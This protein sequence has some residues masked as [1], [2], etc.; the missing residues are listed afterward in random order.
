MH[1]K[2]KIISEN[3]ERL[4]I[5]EKKYDPH[6]GEGSLLEREKVY[7]SDVEANLYLPKSMIN[8]NTF[9]YDLLECKNF[10]DYSNKIGK[11]LAEVFASFQ[12]IRFE[13][14]FE[15]WSILTILIQ[16]KETLEEVPFK[17]RLAQQLLLLELEKMRLAGVPIRI[18]LLKARQWGGSTL[19]QMYMFWIQQIHKERWHLAVCAQDDGAANNISEMYRR[20]SKSYPEAVSTITFKPYARSPK[21]IVNNERGGIIGVGSVNNPDQFR[22]FNYTMLH[23][24]EPGVWEDTPKRTAGQLVAS[25]RSIITKQPLT[26]IA[27]ESTAKGVGTFFHNEWLSAEKES[28]SYKAVFIPW[29]KIEMYQMPITDYSS[30]IDG[31]NE[32]DWFCWKEGATLEGIN[33]YNVH[34]EGENYDDW[35]MYNE[36]PTTSTEAFVASGQRY[37][38]PKITTNARKHVVKPKFRGTIHP[39]ECRSKEDIKHSHFVGTPRG[40]LEIWKM[41]KPLVKVKGKLH[42]CVNRY[43]VFGDIGGVSDKADF[44]S[45]TVLDRY[46]MLYG[47]WPEV[48]ADWHGH[49]D[50]DLFAWIAAQL[51]YLYD[52]ALMA[53][54]TN[55]LRK[56]KSSGDHFLT[57][58]DNIKDH[59]DNLY[60]RNDFE[61]TNKDYIPKYGFHTNSGSKDMILSSLKAGLRDDQFVE[62]QS[63]ACDEFEWFER[64][65]DGTLGAIDGKN[66]DKVI[67][68]AGAYWLAT[69]YMPPVKLIPYES[70]EER[71][72]KRR[73]KGPISEATI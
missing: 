25:L 1:D 52:N 14:D 10:A 45:L 62:R 41:P 19:V 73:N 22:S 44:S 51:G 33:W 68:R 36:F 67:T 53:L 64:K 26:L 18:V 34:K 23:V 46:W 57:V 56:E 47:G 50:Q 32:Y 39:T 12:S 16:H 38:S 49:I 55:S 69:K 31:M 3:K 35:Q 37:F 20:A 66:D 40:P 27:L 24:S 70:P 63:G 4:L 9:I 30:F 72:N 8:D 29:F 17:L 13:H 61:S 28:S 58:L 71:R 21:N 11:D 5:F 15:Y 59:Y 6:T 2:D 42:H 54:E 43:C 65:K 60:I 7:F 48:A